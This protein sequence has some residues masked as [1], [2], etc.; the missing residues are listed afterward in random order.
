MLPAADLNVWVIRTPK[1]PMKLR[2]EHVPAGAPQD[3]P[4]LREPPSLRVDAVACDDGYRAK[5]VEFARQI[6]ESRKREAWVLSVGR[7]GVATLQ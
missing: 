3:C 1:T 7:V 4:T 2:P 5:D 6:I